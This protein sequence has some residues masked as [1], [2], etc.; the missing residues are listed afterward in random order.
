MTR[1]VTA[2]AADPSLEE[3]GKEPGQEPPG[4]V[5]TTKAEAGTSALGRVQGAQAKLVA[6]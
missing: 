6:W 4:R 3:A 2:R 1:E 5:R